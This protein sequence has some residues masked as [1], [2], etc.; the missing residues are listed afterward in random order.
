[1]GGWSPG[2]EIPFSGCEKQKSEAEVAFWR[3]AG[4][5]LVTEIQNFFTGIFMGFSDCPNGH[6]LFKAHYG[7]PLSQLQ[8][9]Q[10]LA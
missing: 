10:A 7:L 9:P 2:K 6:G 5:Y 4:E 8:D 1:M 3:R